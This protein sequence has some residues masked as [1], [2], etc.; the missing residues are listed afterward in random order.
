MPKNQKPHG[1][2]K[3]IGLR[4]HIGIQKSPTDLFPGLAPV[5]PGFSNGWLLA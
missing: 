3:H 2:G 4:N 1:F 5:C